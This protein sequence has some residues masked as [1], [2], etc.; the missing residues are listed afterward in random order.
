MASSPA[1]GPITAQRRM[2]RIGTVQHSLCPAF[3]QHTFPTER[4]AA[5]L[6]PPAFPVNM[7]LKD[8]NAANVN[9]SE[10]AGRD[11]LVFRG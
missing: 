5:Q 10:L 8:Y 4:K 7:A 6:S 3:L 1:F 9:S 11:E 2:F